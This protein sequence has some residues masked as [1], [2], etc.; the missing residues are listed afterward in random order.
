MPGSKHHV[1][2]LDDGQSEPVLHGPDNPPLVS[3]VMQQLCHADGSPHHSGNPGANANAC[4]DGSDVVR[5]EHGQLGPMQP[6]V[7]S[8]RDADAPCYVPAAL[9]RRCSCRT[10]E[11]GR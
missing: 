7:R 11:R 4:P 1:P 10:V 9:E 5:V 3:G 6:L 8:Q 2:D